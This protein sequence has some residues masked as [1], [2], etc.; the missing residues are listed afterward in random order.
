[1][2]G[3][4]S[5][6]HEHHEHDSHG[7]EHKESNPV[8]SSHSSHGSEFHKHSGSAG[9]HSSPDH[10]DAQHKAAFKKMDVWKI[11]TVVL[12]GLL[13]ISVFTNGFSFQKELS[14]QQASEKAL[15]FIN[16]N[17]LQG[18]ASAQVKSIDENSGLQTFQ[19]C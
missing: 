10:H 7:L 6:F 19:D 17:L 14:S 5:E 3:K 2:E 1:M 12:V 4:K 15:T 8:H 18:Q 11:S 16:Q 13:L 9:E